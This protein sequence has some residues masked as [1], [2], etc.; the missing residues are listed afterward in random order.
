MPYLEKYIEI[1][2]ENNHSPENSIKTYKAKREYLIKEID[3]KNEE[4]KLAKMQLIKNIANEN[5]IQIYD[6]IEN[7]NSICI[8]ID[9]D[10]EQS[11]K[12][13]QLLL[14]AKETNLV[15]ENIIKGN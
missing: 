4:E 8:V 13:D 1:E 5:N 3:I 10:K 14:E 12:F 11:L 7:E 2:E 9:S 15:K 6:I